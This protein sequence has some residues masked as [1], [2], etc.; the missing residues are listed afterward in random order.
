[1]HELTTAAGHYGGEMGKRHIWQ[2]SK[3]HDFEATAYEY[4]GKCIVCNGATK[5]GPC[6]SRPMLLAQDSRQRVWIRHT[7]AS[8][9]AAPGFARFPRLRFKK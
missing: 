9:V 7:L 8:T 4:D 2:W 3:E 6:R 1:M 5:Y